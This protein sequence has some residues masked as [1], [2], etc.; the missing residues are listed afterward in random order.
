VTECHTFFTA[1][2]GVLPPTDGRRAMVD[3]VRSE[4]VIFDENRRFQALRQRYSEQ[5][6]KLV[7][8]ANG[9]L[10]LDDLHLY[11]FCGGAI[12]RGTIETLERRPAELFFFKEF[13]ALHER[14]V[15]AVSL[16][17]YPDLWVV[18]ISPVFGGGI[19]DILGTKMSF[20]FEPLDR[21]ALLTAWTE[22]ACERC[23]DFTEYQPVTL[24]GAPVVFHW[25]E[26]QE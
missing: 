14:S 16:F 4:F 2:L 13:M 24:T 9:R 7:A 3:L 26:L 20:A 17:N 21:K 10:H 19:V 12:L 5:L 11:S 8:A 22:M 18:P 23:R 25:T 6:E 15:S 1:I